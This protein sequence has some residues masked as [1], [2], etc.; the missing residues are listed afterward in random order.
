MENSQPDTARPPT[1][2][3]IYHGLFPFMLEIER[4]PFDRLGSLVAATGRAGGE[5]ALAES[6]P[7]IEVQGLAQHSTFLS[8][9]W[10]LVAQNIVARFKTKVLLYVAP[11]RYQTTACLSGSCSLAAS[12]KR[13]TPGVNGQVYGPERLHKPLT[14]LFCNSF[15]PP[16]AVPVQ[17]MSDTR[18]VRE[19]PPCFGWLV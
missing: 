17:P 19:A 6:A 16:S 15:C 10:C 7:R 5:M 12:N 3:S 14:A 2:Q 4:H 8:L 13:E 18:L 11:D 9:Y 1:N